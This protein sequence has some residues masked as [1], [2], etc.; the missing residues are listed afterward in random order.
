MMTVVAIP[1]EVV[2][3]AERA[4]AKASPAVEVFALQVASAA[5]LE[6]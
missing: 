4:R 3:F 5:G 1:V 2:P 6:R